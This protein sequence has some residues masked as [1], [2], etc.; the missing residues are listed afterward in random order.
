MT[1]TPNIPTPRV[2]AQPRSLIGG[3][4]MRHY[5]RERYEPRQRRYFTPSDAGRCARQISFKLLGARTDEKPVPP[6]QWYTRG[7]G[8]AIEDVVTAQLVAEYGDKIACQVKISQRLTTKHGPLSIYGF[9]D[10]C[11]DLD[12]GR[13][14][15][16]LKTTGNYGY[17][18]K[19]AGSDYRGVVTAPEGP[20]DEHVL[21]TAIYGG[22]LDADAIGVSYISRDPLGGYKANTPYITDPELLVAA[23]FRFPMEDVA[24]AASDELDRQAGIMRRV[25]A[26]T[27]AK[28]IIPGCAEITEW[29]HKGLGVWTDRNGRKRTDWACRYC[30]F[31][32]RCETYD[33]GVQVFIRQEADA[34]ERTK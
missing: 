28:R 11:I 19:V 32:E 6:S 23:D 15:W 30:D 1:H 16:D 13:E 29:D 33:N 2:P 34:P 5:E 26:G 9:A 8:Q 20:G 25:E 31:R 24:D 17:G 22:L 12:T 27:I 3:A 14:V 21:Q 7:L 4:F 18:E 10:Y